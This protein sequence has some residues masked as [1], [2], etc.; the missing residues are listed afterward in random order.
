LEA[1]C[2]VDRASGHGIGVL[3]QTH[4]FFDDIS[5]NPPGNHFSRRI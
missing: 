3:L 5:R 1:Q 2:R 4:F